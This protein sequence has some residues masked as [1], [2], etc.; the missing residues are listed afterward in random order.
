LNERG[1][2]Q[3][4][5]APMS[6]Y[7]AHGDDRRDIVLAFSLDALADAARRGFCHTTDQAL[8]ALSR[9]EDR[10]G[11][12]IAVNPWRS[13]PVAAFRH[14]M[15]RPGDD[16]VVD[17]V[18]LVRPLRLRR[19]DPTRMSALRQSY[20]RYDRI[21]ERQVLNLGLDSPAV[22]TFNPLVAAFCPL[23]WASSVTYYAQDDWASYSPVAP[24]WPAYRHAYTALRERGAR[25][26]SVSDELATRLTAGGPA[27]IIPNGINPDEWIKSSPVPSV[28]EKLTRPIVTYLGTIDGRLNVDLVAKIAEDCAVGSIAL[29]G[30]CQDSMLQHRLRSIQKVTLCGA[31]S[32]AEVVG[33]LRYSDACAIPH[34]VTPLTRAMS[35]MKVYEYL[36]AGKP[37][38]TTML[39]ALNGISARVI[40]VDDEE[41]PAAVRTA[42]D[43]PPQPENERLDFVRSNSWAARL[44]RMFHVMLADQADW[45]KS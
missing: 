5:R 45:W 25:I 33:A 27:A 19:R 4:V 2:G 3:I 43:L 42:L 1:N 32:R 14:F 39:P 40:S 44:E 30:P 36:A 15:P 24:W 10:I 21:I 26:I 18:T 13:A 20:R 41:F 23:R 7:F 22:L 37:V 9:A 29:I 28:V 38:A 35:P 8:L 17:R 11:R 6:E 34:V 16:V 31:M 12:I